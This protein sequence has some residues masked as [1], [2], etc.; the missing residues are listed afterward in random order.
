MKKRFRFEIILSI[1]FECCLIE[2]S[3]S[4]QWRWIN[5]I[6]NSFR[7]IE[8]L[9]VLPRRFESGST[10]CRLLI[11]IC[12]IFF[13]AYPNKILKNSSKFFS[14]GRIKLH[15]QVN[16][17]IILNILYLLPKVI[18]E[19]IIV[20]FICFFYCINA[21]LINIKIFIQQLKLCKSL[22]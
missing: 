18:D 12:S 1:D 5:N 4:A 7:L 10:C 3:I 20:Y 15:F 14:F 21:L 2:Q 19:L 8:L 9:R 16:V 6:L 17:Q 22:C 11:Q 13:I